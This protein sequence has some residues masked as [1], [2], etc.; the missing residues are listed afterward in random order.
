M[1]T[2]DAIEPSTV[3]FARGPN[4][5][6]LPLRD[7]DPLPSIGTARINILQPLTMCRAYSCDES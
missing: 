3:A 6:I 5:G 4:R 7:R 1:F 2:C